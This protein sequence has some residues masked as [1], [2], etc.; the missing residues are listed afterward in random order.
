MGTWVSSQRSKRDALS[1][2]R[3]R[4]LEAVDEWLWDPRAAAWEKGF[5]QLTTY[6]QAE[7]YAG[8]PDKYRTA[9]GFGLGT[10]VSSQRSKRDAL[11]AERQQRLEALDGWM[12]DPYAAAWDEGFGHLVAYVEA[13]GHGRVPQKH[14]T[15][16]G[17]GLGSWVNSQRSAKDR[18]SADRRQRLGDVEGWVW[19]AA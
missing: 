7:G 2:E 13:E 12:W 17:F 19:K 18:M 6:V 4:R 8:V 3:R 10:W 5:A 16:T 15:A 1:A 11:S 14:R 9:T